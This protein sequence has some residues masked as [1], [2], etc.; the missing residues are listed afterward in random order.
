MPLA[1]VSATA[2]ALGGVHTCIIATEGQVK[3][4]GYNGNGEL[5]IGP[6]IAWEVWSPVDVAGELSR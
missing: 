3:C 2:I 1:E 6:G 5:G 4:W